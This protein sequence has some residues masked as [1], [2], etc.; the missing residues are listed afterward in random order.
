[1]KKH[2]TTITLALCL[3]FL[4]GY[5]GGKSSQPK[6]SNEA[7][8]PVVNS[9]DLSDY[10]TSEDVSNTASIEAIQLEALQYKVEQ[11]E[12]QLKALSQSSSDTESADR[13]NPSKTTKA[14]FFGRPV[15]PNQE[16]LSAAGM[17]T[18]EADKLLRR[19]S[20]QEYQRLELQNNIR[21]NQ[22][23]ASNEY[24]AQLRELNQNKISLRS[25]LGDDAYDNYLFAS[26]Q[27]NRV[28]ISSVMADSPAESSGFESNDIILSYDDQKILN[29]ADIRRVTLEGDIGSY[30]NVNILRNG[31]S[32]SLMVP[33]G[34]LGVQLE[35]V[36][37]DPTE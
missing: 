12:V 33:R 34:T 30:T 6:H 21:R 27:N 28:K 11:L 16:N 17:S 25:E 7:S 31:E 32:M 3:G 10:I 29:W 35:P 14:A 26:Q 20:Q 13:S 19:M 24:R 2:L 1:M 4:G 18:D 23:A 8:L 22:G 37:L 5:L 9:S 15:Q 36:Q